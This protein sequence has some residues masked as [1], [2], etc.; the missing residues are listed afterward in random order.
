MLK[1]TLVNYIKSGI[2]KG[3]DIKAL[4]NYMEKD[5]TY[6][7]IAV[8]I[9]KIHLFYR[10][11]GINEG[12]KVA[13]VGKNSVHW[14]IIYLATITY[15]AVI[16]PL[17]PDFRPEDI[18]KLIHHSDALALFAEIS[19][20]EPLDPKTFPKIKTVV[21]L[22]DFSLLQTSEKKT[23]SFFREW[24]Q[25]F[26]KEYP[27]GYRKEDLI[28][29][30]ITNDKLAVISYTSGTTGNSKGVMLSHNSL[31]ANVRYAHN[32]MPLEAGDRIVSFLPLAHAYGCAF[33]FLFP[34]TLGCHITFL[35]KTPSPQIITK[36][37][38]EIKPRLILS[39]PLVIEK[40]YK[41]NIVPSLRKPVMQIL[42]KTPL[43]NKLLYKTINKKIHHVFGG[44]FREV[45]IGGAAFNPEAELFFTKIKFPFTV[46]YGMT[47]CGPLISYASWNTRKLLSAG[48]P[49]DTL[50]VRIDSSDPEKTAGEILVKG[51]NV[52]DGYYKNEEATREVLEPDGWLHTGDLGTIDKEKNIFIRGRSKNMILGPSG[53]NIYPEDIETVMNNHPLVGDSLVV[54]REH[55]IVAL[56]YP[57]PDQMKKE[58]ITED[59]LPEI[60]DDIRKTVNRELASF[61]QIHKIEVR[62]EDFQRTP[63][64]NIKRVKYQ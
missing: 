7:E 17:L 2:S 48:R 15:G 37:F 25:R 12:D 30:E 53:Q 32:H 56:V 29:P 27:Q 51:D 54:N 60:M 64:R 63:K 10:D 24:D 43:I 31:A 1:E 41:K 35:T 14:A 58:S 40:I 55:L 13:L 47:E 8:L 39:V 59:K 52:M 22:D 62:K 42:L 34:F 61:M 21:K 57:D 11:N 38:D 49:V 26:K 46:G 3:W 18:Q 45:V 33:E 44:I 4:S 6:R 19:L 23:E 36:A 50:D 16:V 5:F 28:Y 20:F 9:A